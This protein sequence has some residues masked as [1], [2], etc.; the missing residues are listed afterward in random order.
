MAVLIYNQKMDKVGSEA[1]NLQ[2]G[3]RLIIIF[4]FLAILWFALNFLANKV[5]S[6]QWNLPDFF[7]K[8]IR[9]KALSDKYKIELV[10]K[11]YLADGCEALVV[12]V[13]GKDL[14]LSRSVNGSVAFIKELS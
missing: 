8:G 1:L 7:K 6:G 10:Q 11:Q 9:P 12:S 13:D 2:V 5:K 14:L 4:V 3:K